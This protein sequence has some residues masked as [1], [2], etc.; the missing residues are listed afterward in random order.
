MEKCVL[1]DLTA[2]ADAYE[3]QVYLF[4]GKFK[5][6]TED[7]ASDGLIRTLLSRKIYRS[8][9]ASQCISAGKNRRHADILSKHLIK[10]KLPLNGDVKT[11]HILTP[12]GRV[13]ASTNSMEIGMDYSREAFFIGGKSTTTEISARHG[14]LPEI[15]ISTP[16]LH[17]R[18][19]SLIGVLVN[20]IQISKLNEIFSGE[21]LQQQSAISHLRKW[22]MMDVYLVND[23]KLMITAS[24][25][26]KDAVLRQV[27]DTP[28]V[29]VGFAS[30]REMAGFYRNYL[31]KEVLG[32]SMVIPSLKWVLLV[33]VEKDNALIPAKKLLKNALLTVIV[34]A[35][36]LALLLVVF[37][38]KKIV[39]PVHAISD[40][41][42]QIAGGNLKVA[43]PVTRGDEIGILCESFNNMVCHL[44][45]KISDQARLTMVLDATSDFVGIA[46]LDGK[47]LYLNTAARK[48]LDVENEVADATVHISGV[49]T[50]WAATLLPKEGVSFAVQNGVWEGENTFLTRNGSE[51]TVS[52]VIIAHKDSGGDVHYLSTIARNITERKHAE[53]LLRKS[54]NK[55]RTL[56]ENLPQKIFYKDMHS[57]YITCNENYAR[58][59]KI[60]PEEICG[61]TDYDFYPKE[62]AEKYR[63]NDRRI[64]SLGLPE[65]LEDQYISNGREL[66]V[67]TV[68]TPVRDEKGAVTGIL[69]IFWD[70]TEFKQATTE[71][72][73]MEEQLYQMQKLD[74]LGTL[75][76]GIAHDFNNIL[77]LIMGYGSLLEK[78]ME[79]DNPLKGYVQQ[80]LE[81][82]ER[83]AH[84]TQG[85]LT[86][87]RKHQAGNQAPVSVNEIIKKIKVLLQSIIP[88]NICLR[89]ALTREECIV[90][91]NFNQI[92]QALVNLATNAIHAMPQGG[93]LSISSDVRTFDSEYEN[94]YGHLKA[95]AY[96]LI[97]VADTGI[98]MDKKTL[99]RIF[100]PFFTTKEVG[101]GTGI[102]L[103]VVY[104][105]VTQHKGFIDVESRPGKGTTFMVYLPLT[106][107]KVEEIEKRASEADPYPPNGT[108]TVLIAE[109]EARVL[110]LTE[111]IFT[112]H[113]YK[114]ITASDG[115]DAIEKFRRNKE[116]I[117]LVVLD[118]RMPRK[119]GKEAYD[120]I[121]T[122]QPGIKVLFMSGY[123]RDI[124][125][126]KEIVEEGS[127]FILKPVLA[128]E[129]LMK[130]RKILDEGNERRSH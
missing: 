73:K 125:N 36:M 74:S 130:A 57:T 111:T 65:E 23:A 18:T 127:N 62:L 38:K 67:R 98:G 124:A 97:S 82:S 37:I 54:E 105:I 69:G 55:Y 114:V 103:A 13:A 89:M 109:D 2:I 19:G 92:E 85:L 46:D 99:S 71:R 66:I 87:S 16:I 118:V 76:G 101:K 1:D 75:A 11:I 43:I 83:A 126:N 116:E 14:G 113:G 21:Y 25:Y 42:R 94:A 35:L 122:I 22:K 32:A 120:A 129:L 51:V 8:R 28:P 26:V 100:E 91:A 7:F 48:M 53:E 40:A 123:N 72:Q 15:A 3:G 110:G 115:E 93:S 17:L 96:A 4:L 24:A 33:E 121:K 49:Y 56:L 20:F 112:Q 64:M 39:R 95:G 60:R 81:S 59:L 34:V 10:N 31:G 79:K 106:E 104:G 45:N 63:A 117:Q 5:Q 27:V 47:A 44:K 90:T 68:K 86:F 102:G 6:T 30:N 80:I 52:Q 61:K 70:I 29:T 128:Q 58:D 50:Q 77:A 9:D 88:E 107:S 78:E 41:A 84:L 119:N 108:E 12:D